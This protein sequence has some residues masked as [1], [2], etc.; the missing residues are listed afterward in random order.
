MKR[1]FSAAL[2]VN[3]TP[4]IHSGVTVSYEGRQDDPPLLTSLDLEADLPS[5][6]LLQSTA[7]D[8]NRAD[9]TRRIVWRKGRYFLF[10]DT[11]KALETGDYRIDGRWRLLSARW[12]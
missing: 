4:A 11:V 3:P 5:T 10:I 9:W 1:A 2:A 7:G 12:D 8:F 6:G